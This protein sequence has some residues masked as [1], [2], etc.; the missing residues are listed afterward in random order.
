VLAAVR[1][2]L[3]LVTLIVDEVEVA[4]NLYHTPYVVVEVAPP[5]E[6]VGD[7]LAA[8]CIFGCVA[9]FEQLVDGVRVAAVAQ[10]A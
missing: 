6:P 10:V 4:V 5:Q 2:A 9:G 8:F 3:R 7:A 1:L